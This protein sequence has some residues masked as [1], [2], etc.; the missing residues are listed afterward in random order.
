[1]GGERYYTFNRK[2]AR[3]FVLDSNQ[4]DPKQ[5]AWID[6]ALKQSR[7]EW[8]ICYFHH[9]LYSDGGRHG[10][11]VQ[12]RVALE[13]L[14]VKYGVNVVFSGHDHI[15]E[16]LTAAERDHLLRRRLGRRVAKGRRQAVG[17]HRGLLRPGSS[18]HARG[19]CR[20][21][22]VLSRRFPAP[23]RPSTPASS[24]GARPERRTDHESHA[25]PPNAPITPARSPG[26]DPPSRP[27]LGSVARLPSPGSL[28]AAAA[29]RRD[30][31]G[32]GEQR[33]R[34]LLH[35]RQKLSFAVNEIGMAF[36]FAL[37]TQEIVEAVMPGGALHTWRRWGLPVVAA[38]GGIVGSVAVYLT[39][40]TLSHEIVLTTAWPIACAID[41]AAAYYLLKTIMPRSAALPFALLVG[42]ATD[43][44]GILVVAPRY[45]TI[46]IH[47][48]GAVLLLM[49]IGLAGLLRA[50]GVRA[51]WPYLSI[52]GTDLVVGVFLGRASIRRSP[53][54]RLSPSC[55]MSRAGSICSRIHPTMTRFTTSSTSGM[56]SSRC[57]LF[58]FGLVNAGVLLRGYDTGS[59][60]MIVAALSAGR[61]GFWPRSAWRCWR[62]CTCHG[63]SAGA[64]WSSSR[65]RPRAVS[66][67]RCSSRPGWSR[68]DQC[69]PK[70]RS[71]RWRPVPACFSRSVPPGCSASA[72]LA[73]RRRGGER[74]RSGSNR[75]DRSE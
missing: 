41:V 5:L 12:L 44:F 17:D 21:R 23:A 34:K 60:A 65:W 16:R 68:S 36:F 66:R 59:S 61:S 37:A 72:D 11:D 53:W 20:R 33:R 42:I 3:F 46:A 2:N 4:M 62:V 28:P 75:G 74:W 73:D 15:Y 1:M 22:T 38:A 43:A 56:R 47:A 58:F 71:V 64:S 29:R 14:L 50:I 31:P 49:A 7:D 57:I 19:N 10:S 51:F 25:R 67:S 63:I 39:Y 18:V 32:V 6:D 70:S 27:T 9:P 40:V 45:P 69:A 24:A 13:P 54:C 55:R 52:C 48:S 35:V 26:V 8:K 30:R